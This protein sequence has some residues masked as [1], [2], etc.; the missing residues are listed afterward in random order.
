MH[1]FNLSP[2][3]S[4]DWG[5]N[6]SWAGELRAHQDSNGTVVERRWLCTY[7]GALSERLHKGSACVPS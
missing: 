2:L 1:L 4:C 3:R 7:H 6:C 5:Y